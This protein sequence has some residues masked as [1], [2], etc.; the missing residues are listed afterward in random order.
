METGNAGMQP[1][2]AE[3]ERGADAMPVNHVVEERKVPLELTKDRYR[4]KV[5]T[6]TGEEEVE[7]FIQEFS[8]VMDVAQWP[9]GWPC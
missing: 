2:T 1:P 3:G 7:Q 6:F 4:L 5:P 9:L 8:D